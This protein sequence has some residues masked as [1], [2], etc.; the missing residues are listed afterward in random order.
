MA[1]F[2]VKINIYPSDRGDRFYISHPGEMLE[3]LRGKKMATS[4]AQKKATNR[5]R[6]DK[7]EELRFQVP[8]GEKQAIKDFASKQ[9]LSVSAFVYSV[10][11][12]AMNKK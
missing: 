7:I 9:G 4:E 10:V 5:Y 12:E 1:F 11:K 8:K 2:I 3:R 6:K